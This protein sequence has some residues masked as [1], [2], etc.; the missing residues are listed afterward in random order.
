VELAEPRNVV[1]AILESVIALGLLLALVMPG[2]GPLRAR[3]VIGA[4]V[5]ALIGVLV[6]QVALAYGIGPRTRGGDLMYVAMIAIA[7]GSML[8]IAWPRTPERVPERRAS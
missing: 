7:F 5:L 4:Q 2:R 8:A 6:G 3:R 1:A